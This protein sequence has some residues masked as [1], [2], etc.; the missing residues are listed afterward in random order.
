[1]ADRKKRGAT[2][3]SMSSPRPRQLFRPCTR[4]DMLKKMR[5]VAVVVMVVTSTVAQGFGPKVWGL[6]RRMYRMDGHTFD[7]LAEL[8][9]P[10]LERNDYYPSESREIEWR[11]ARG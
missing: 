10:I 2:V 8:L 4:Q 9:R 11:Y 6:F 1:M 7:K 5:A 3:G